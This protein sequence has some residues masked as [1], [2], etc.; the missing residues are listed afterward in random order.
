MHGKLATVSVVGN[1]DGTHQVIADSMQAL[2]DIGFTLPAQGA[3]CWN[4]EAM[5]P[6]DYEDLEET[7]EAVAS[8]NEMMAADAV[9]LA[10]LPRARQYPATS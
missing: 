4:A 5:N 8:M 1:E 3:T 7:P 9:H 10:K 6:R 2:N